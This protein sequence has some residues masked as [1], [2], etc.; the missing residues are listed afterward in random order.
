MQIL[1]P[2]RSA[3][4][5]ACQQIYQLSQY[6]SHFYAY[7]SKYAFRSIFPSLNNSPAI[8][9]SSKCDKW[10]LGQGKIKETISIKKLAPTII[11]LL[12]VSSTSAEILDSSYSYQDDFVE[13]FSAM[14]TDTLAP[15]V[16]GDTAWSIAVNDSERADQLVVV[17]SSTDGDQ[18][19]AFNSMGTSTDRH[20]SFGKRKG[21]A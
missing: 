8:N 19:S 14:G 12:A 7:I 17:D 18:Q 4:L 3:L 13:S 6:L 16:N 9:N 11:L 10:C 20:L 5:T 15:N 21:Q 1:P 2:S